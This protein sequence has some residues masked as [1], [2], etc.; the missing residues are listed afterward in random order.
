[1]RLERSFATAFP[2]LLLALLASPVNAGNR[3]EKE[4]PENIARKAKVTA[5]SEYSNQ[6]RAANVIDGEIPGA[7]SRADAGEAW[8]V[9]GR[10][11]KDRGELT[12]AWD[13][14]GRDCGTRVVRQDAFGMEECWKDYELLVDDCETILLSGKLEKTDMPQRVELPRPQ[15]LQKR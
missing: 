13:T 15:K 5:S 8:C 7:G 2:G 6:Y 3:F 1:M 4:L 14:P 11:A 12:L 9:P 10:T